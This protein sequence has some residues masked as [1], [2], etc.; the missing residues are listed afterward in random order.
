M[1][2]NALFAAALL[3]ASDPAPARHE[4]LPPG[5]TLVAEVNGWRITEDYGACTAFRA[6]GEGRT[7]YLRYRADEDAVVLGTVDPAWQA[8]ENGRPDRLTIAFLPGRARA[9]SATSIGT[10]RYHRMEGD[11]PAGVTSDFAGREL[12]DRLAGS[13]LVRIALGTV[14]LRAVEVAGARELVQ[15]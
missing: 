6:L 14:A 13:A 1:L 12:L 4:A 2:L 10:S 5:V 8:I 9:V 11:G 15:R 7:L 3:A